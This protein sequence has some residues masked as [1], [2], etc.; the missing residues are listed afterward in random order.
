MRYYQCDFIQ[1][2]RHTT[3]WIEERGAI[4]GARVE[5][6]DPGLAG[7][8]WEVRKVYSASFEVDALKAKQDRDRNCFASI[9]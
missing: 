9:R 6:K 7:H 4:E 8:L 1:G 2:N 5:L 3:G